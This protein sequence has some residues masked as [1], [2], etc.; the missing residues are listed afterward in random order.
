FRTK[1]DSRTNSVHGHIS[2]SDNGNFLSGKIRV[3]TF[4]DITEETDCG[5]YALG[6]LA[7]DV[8]FFICAG[9]D[10]DQDCIVGSAQFLYGDVLPD[11]ETVFYFDA[12]IK[13]CLNV[14][15][16]T[17]FRKTVVWNTITEHTAKFRK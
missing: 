1:S 4:S 17:V 15:V 12:G 11:T 13:N 2:A 8:E 10:S 14:F 7:F 5:H 9:S 16:E 6:V 3:N